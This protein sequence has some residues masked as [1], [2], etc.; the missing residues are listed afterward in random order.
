MA[1]SGG[2]PT[3]HDVGHTTKNSNAMK[4]FWVAAAVIVGIAL[5]FLL[6]SK[7]NAP[8]ATDG[9]SGSDPSTVLTEENIYGSPSKNDG[10]TV[11]GGSAGGVPAPP[12]PGGG[13]GTKPPS[14]K[15]HKPGPVHIGKG[16]PI[17]HQNGT[18]S[19]TGSNIAST[20]GSS[21]T[22]PSNQ[23]SST[24]QSSGQTGLVAANGALLN[25]LGTL[26]SNVWNTTLV[27]IGKGIHWLIWGS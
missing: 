6:L 17:Y 11:A 2:L 1:K 7:R 18:V 12:K 27:P 8:G 4:T 16:H 13:G 3:I 26:G 25:S 24:N 5:V 20:A 14:H 23:T 10:T 9:S 21:Y 15:S 19:Y 22:P